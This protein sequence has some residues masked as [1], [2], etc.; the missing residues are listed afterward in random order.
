MPAKPTNLGQFATDPGRTLE[1][2]LAEKGVG[3]LGAKK[4]PARWLN[5]AL[6]NSYL[7]N[8]WLDA[9][10]STSHLWTAPQTFTAGIVVNDLT[11]L[12]TAVRGLAGNAASD[13]GVQGEAGNGASSY[14]TTGIGK[15]L[16]GQGSH[17]TKGVG[18]AGTGAGA[19]GGKGVTGIGGAATSVDGE[20]GAGVTGNGGAGGATGIGVGGR[21]GDFTGGAAA[22]AGGPAVVGL[23]GAGT[24]A[25]SIGGPGTKAIGGAIDGTTNTT[26]AGGAGGVFTGGAITSDANGRRGGEAIHATGGLGQAGYGPALHS[27]HGGIT[28]DDGDLSVN[29]IA[30]FSGQLSANGGITLPAPSGLTPTA[31][32]TA[33]AQAPACWKNAFGEVSVQGGLVINTAVSGNAGF[34]LP[35][36]HRPVLQC[37]FPLTP[38]GAGGVAWA[39][40]HTTGVVNIFFSP[41]FGQPI[42][43]DPIRFRNT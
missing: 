37:T 43:L 26:G 27:D 8:Q 32:F 25:G 2:L 39:V 33:A 34:T 42:F 28:L 9:Y 23:G 35:A 12:H 24:G 11:G 5:W 21:G 14:G 30:T 13:I 19:F 36:T 40:V 16:A 3:F 4:L 22:I 29:G 6:N 31:P 18:G 15:S 38:D 17:G 10:E 20:G 1:P 41:G 7:W